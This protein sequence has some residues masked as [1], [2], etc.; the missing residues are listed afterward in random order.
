MAVDAS[1][2]TIQSISEDVTYAVQ[3]DATDENA[4]KAMGIRN[5]DVA[6]ITI[7]ANVQASI[8]VTLMVKELGIKHIVAKAQ[9]EMHAKV[10]YKIGADRVV[11][12][13][14]EMGVR[15]AKNL[16]SNK[17]LD[18]IELSE[19]YTIAEV[20]PLKEWIGKSLIEINIRAKHGIHVIALKGAEGI[21]INVGPNEVIEEHSIL[22]VIGHNDDIKRVESAV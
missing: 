3:A 1:E 4:L 20:P 15:V 2:E 17:I 12:P 13:E 11:F 9:N 19:E 14:R 7:G 5:F 22:V 18:Y 6:V 8:M 16:V 21:N 10:L